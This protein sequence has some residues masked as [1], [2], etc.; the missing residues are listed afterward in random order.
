MLFFSVLY[1]RA[2][3][4]KP[5][6]FDVSS[7]IVAVHVQDFVENIRNNTENVKNEIVSIG[8]NIIESLKVNVYMTDFGLACSVFFRTEFIHCRKLVCSYL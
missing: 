6:Q 1:Q 3:V 7:P 4:F 2:E 8:R 5:N